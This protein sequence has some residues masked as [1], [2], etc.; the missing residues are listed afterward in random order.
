MPVKREKETKTSRPDKI[1]KDQKGK[2]NVMPDMSIPYEINVS[3]KKIEVSTHKDLEIEM[4][5]MKAKK[6]SAYIC[7]DCAID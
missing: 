7:L 5:K 6:A 1:M 3:I 4:I 2:K